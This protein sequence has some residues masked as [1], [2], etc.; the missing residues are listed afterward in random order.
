MYSIIIYT[1]A[2]ENGGLGPTDTE[3]GG[4]GPTDTENGGLGPTDT[5]NGGLGPTVVIQLADPL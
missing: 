3:N 5:E 2:T 1:G 4:L